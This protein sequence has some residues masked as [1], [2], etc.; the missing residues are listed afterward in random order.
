M[1]EG[2]TPFAELEKATKAPPKKPGRKLIVLSGQR[3]G[4]LLVLTRE[5]PEPHR[6]R[7]HCLCDC[8]RMH[9]VE[10]T[11]LRAGKVQSCGCLRAEMDLGRA[12]ANARSSTDSGVLNAPI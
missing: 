10:G 9:I 4:R 8:G 11:D 3:F 6:A 12:K 1:P 5:A 7:W 2:L